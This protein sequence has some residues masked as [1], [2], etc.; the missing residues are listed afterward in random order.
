MEKKGP[1][2]KANM[3]QIRPNFARVAHVVP[4]AYTTKI[5]PR[6]HLQDAGAPLVCPD[7]MGASRAH[8]WW[9]ISHRHANVGC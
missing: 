2:P 5:G 9:V 6:R 7:P 8:L 4:K 1:K 3:L